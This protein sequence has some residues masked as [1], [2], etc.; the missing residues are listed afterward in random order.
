MRKELVAYK[1]TNGFWCCVF[2][3]TYSEGMN[4]TDFNQIVDLIK[5]HYGF[6]ANDDFTQ[7]DNE[8]Y[9]LTSVEFVINPG[10]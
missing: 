3:V 5:T 2:N 1:D 4:I 7:E 9:V 10:I 8:I 6:L